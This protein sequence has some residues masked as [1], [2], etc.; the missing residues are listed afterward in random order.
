MSFPLHFRS[1]VCCY[2]LWVETMR[3]LNTGL[4]YSVGFAMSLSITEG[5]GR[6]AQTSTHGDHAATDRFYCWAPPFIGG[7]NFP[8]I[9]RIG[10]GS[11]PCSATR[12]WFG[13]I[14]TPKG[15]AGVLLFELEVSLSVLCPGSCLLLV[16]YWA[17]LVVLV[18]VLPNY[19]CSSRPAI[20]VTTQQSLDT[21]HFIYSYLGHSSTVVSSF[22]FSTYTVGGKGP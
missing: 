16:L 1:Q 18:S 12:Q 13:C 19:L 20:V 9:H 8:V 10:K 3:I 11:Q 6:N 7:W 14:H 4:C 21:A 17:R 15:L 2:K 22:I 5:G